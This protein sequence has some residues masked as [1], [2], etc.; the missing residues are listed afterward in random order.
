MRIVSL[1]PSATE[2][3]YLLGAEEDVIGVSHDSDYP[4]EVRRKPVVSTSVIGDELSSAEIDATIG[5]TYHAGSSIYHIDP[6]FLERERPDL[7]VAQELCQVCAVTSAAA[8]RAAEIARSGARIVSLE[9]T[10]LDETLDSILA[11]GEAVE[12]SG[13]ALELVESIRARMRAVADRMA[14]V[15]PVRTLCLG[16]LDP[17]IV[18][19]HWM[20]ELVSMAGGQPLSVVAGGPSQRL[21]W[22]E[23]AA[24]DPDALIL[25]PCSFSLA[26]TLSEVHVLGRH[27]GWDDLV[28]VRSGR[29]Y[30]VDSAYFS[31][32]GPRLATGLEILARC[33][34]PEWF[35]GQIPTDAAARLSSGP[36]GESAF[37]P[38]V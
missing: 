34:H 9:P 23:V 22:Q 33:L 4:P 18:E 8:R 11:L 2:V 3:L 14:G 26:R 30:A 1:L 7:I 35:P 13:A 21:D 29:V 31:R 16:W 17:L 38:V 37:V 15:P 19:G 10:T 36:V 27:P 32:P 28:A 12:R 24:L 20:P 5:Q 6:E 25:T